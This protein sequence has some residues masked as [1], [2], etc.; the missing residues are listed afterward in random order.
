MT[1]K[2]TVGRFET[3]RSN[4]PNTQRKNLE[5]LLPDYKKQVCN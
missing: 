3:S 2:M 5:D 4:Y 1:L